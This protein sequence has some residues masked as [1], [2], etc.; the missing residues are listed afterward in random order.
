MTEMIIDPSMV[1]YRHIIVEG[2]VT[3]VCVQ[4]FDYPDYRFDSEELFATEQEAQEAADE[5][6]VPYDEFEWTPYCWDDCEMCGCHGLCDGEPWD[7]DID[8]EEE[9]E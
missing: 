1:H 6:N 8:Y 2:V 7:E 5:A 9:D 4:D 3:V